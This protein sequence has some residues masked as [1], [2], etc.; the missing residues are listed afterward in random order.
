MP[1]STLKFPPFKAPKSWRPAW[2]SSRSSFAT[3]LG[4]PLPRRR[5]QDRCI[6][7]GSEHFTR[8][9]AAYD[10]P[11]TNP[12]LRKMFSHIAGPELDERIAWAVDDLAELL[13]RAD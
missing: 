8:E 11:K 5:K 2:Q 12:F 4:K 6:K 9:H 13:H 3:R 7:K 1:S 10:L